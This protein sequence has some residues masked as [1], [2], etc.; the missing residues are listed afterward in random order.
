MPGWMESLCGLASVGVDIFLL[1]SGLGLW[2][3]L[4][5][6][7]AT[8]HRG[9]V[10]QWYKRRYKRILV[11]YLLIAGIS[12]ILA[13]TRGG[14][15]ITAILNL[16]TVNYWINHQ[17][18]WYIAMLIPLYAIT[19]VYDWFLKKVRQ[20]VLFTLGLVVAIVG[21]SSVHVQIADVSIAKIQENIR[22]V[23][24]HLPPF[25]IGY[26]LAPM[27]KEQKNVSLLWMIIVPLLITAA[28]K[29]LHFGYWPGFLVFIFVPLLCWVIKHCG[30]MVNSIFE[31]F[32][33]ISLESYL[34]NTTVGSWII[35]YLP[36]IYYS[37]WNQG[38]YL[39]YALVCVIGTL[40]AYMVHQLCKKVFF[41]S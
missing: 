41:K 10:I 5:S 33:K 19:P 6:T 3:S 16:S 31:F 22:H 13:I 25:F 9:G 27:A 26:L 37:S 2:Y 32:G 18:A 39:H 34:F 38:C 17:G 11:P 1:V 28:M 36:W 21:L 4:R 15:V 24:V 12:S 23:A 40:L 29:F 14:S 35:A 20:P 8:H 7:E 30:K